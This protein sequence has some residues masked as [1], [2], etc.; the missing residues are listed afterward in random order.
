M[1]SGEQVVADS[2]KRFGP[3]GE[4]APFVVLEHL[5]FGGASVVRVVCTTDDESQAA[6]VAMAMS[7]IG[8]RVWF[9]D[10]Q[11]TADGPTISR[12]IGG[13]AAAWLNAQGEDA[14]HIGAA[15]KATDA[16]W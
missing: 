5:L 7:N 1:S 13:P 16:G 6:A 8:L 12:Y 2:P 10:L 15:D 14:T 11:G 3:F 9:V 4:G